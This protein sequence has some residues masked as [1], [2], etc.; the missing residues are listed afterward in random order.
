YREILEQE[1]REGRAMYIPLIMRDSA[2]EIKQRGIEEGI[3]KGIA[4]GREEGKL[5]VARNLLASGMPPEV[6]AKSAGLPLERIRG[7]I[8]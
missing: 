2:A 6:I 7:L 8:N 1:N 5:E 3:E 4:K